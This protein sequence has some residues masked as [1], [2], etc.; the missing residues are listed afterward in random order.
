VSN[1]AHHPGAA[2]TDDD[3]AH[4]AE[5]RHMAHH[6]RTVMGLTLASRFSGLVRESV[7]A[8]MFGASPIW[9]AW[10]TAFIVP[11]LFRRLFGE[12]AI[13]AAFIPEYARLVREDKPRAARLASLTVAGV[14]IVLG[15]IVVIAEIVLISLLLGPL[16]APDAVGRQVALY[17]A[18]M[19]PYAP[20]V[21]GTAILGGM[22]QAH[23]SFAQLAGGPIILNFFITFAA[24]FAVSSLGMSLEL[25]ALLLSISVLGA[26]IAQLGWSIWS[27]RGH[28]SWTRDVA[29]VWGIFLTMLKRMVPVILGMAT[30]Q[31]GTIVDSGLAGMPVMAGPNPWFLGG[32][33]YPL[34]PG[35]A[36]TLF[37]AN[38]LYQFPLGVFGIAIATVAFPAMA[39]QTHRHEAFTGTVRRGLR[40]GA[41]IAFPATVGLMMV[42]RPLVDT[43]YLGGNFTPDDAVRVTGVL[44][45]FAPAILAYSLTHVLTRAFYAN[46]LTRAPM[47][48]GMVTVGLNIIGSVSLMWPMQERGLAAATSAASFVQVAILLAMAPR[49]I[50]A[51]AGAPVLDRATW[52]SFL[53]SFLLTGAM[54]IAILVVG[55]ILPIGTKGWLG[56]VLD[57][58]RDVGVGGSAYLGAAYALHR[59]ELRWLLQRRTPD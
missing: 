34:E 59:P 49:R 54:V 58:S 32:A 38:R 8:R 7:C 45:A 43:V 30:L 6:A 50:P 28:T 2:P 5:D 27:L 9:D 55:L 15:V 12:G 4:A 23:G 20:L 40:T 24:W 16:A 46:G 37:Y 47:V 29:D 57:L 41:F 42:A 53:A 19:L 31:L 1:E 51:F 52:R 3:R 11:N 48:A 10:A 33:R 39:R 13:S 25:S 56:S 21:C 35:A 22:L 18:I 17:T 26:G 36:S 14:T 44:A